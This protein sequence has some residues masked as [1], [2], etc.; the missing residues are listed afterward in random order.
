[1]TAAAIDVNDA[2]A[3]PYPKRLV[4]DTSQKVD[5]RVAD[6]ADDVR[7]RTSI[8]RLNAASN[9]RITVRARA[10]VNEVELPSINGNF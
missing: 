5:R 6:D 2:V 10:T 3:M 4:T 7:I 9:A 8:L 1:M